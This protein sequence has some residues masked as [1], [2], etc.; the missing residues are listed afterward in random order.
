MRDISRVV[1]K[2][3]LLPIP[4]KMNYQQK[5]FRRNRLVQSI[6]YNC[7]SGN[8]EGHISV[9]VSNTLEHEETKLRIAYKLKLEGF[10]VW[11]E[12]EFTS[13]GR[14]DLIAIKDGKGYIIEVLHSETE[15]QLNEKVKKYPSEFEMISVRTKDFDLDSFEI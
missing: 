11:S 4:T 13:G 8:K 5:M 15:K 3:L 12:A 1:S 2:F 10:E 14:A 6:K 7:R 9:W